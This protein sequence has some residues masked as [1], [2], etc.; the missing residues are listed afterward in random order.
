VADTLGSLLDE[1]TAA[2]AEAGRV[3][4]RRRARQLI[5]SSLNISAAELLMYPDRVL[6]RSEA[7]RLLGLVDRMTHG[8]PLS[9][10]LGRREFW[11]LDF[12]LSNE[13]LDPR[14]ESETVVEA[15][16]SRVCDRLSPLRLLDLGTGTGCL[17]LALLS[18][19]PAAT[20][21]GVDLSEEAVATARRNAET[22]G[23]GGRACFFVGEWSS[24]LA[25][26]FDVIVANPPYVATA[27]LRDLPDE[28][29]LYDP[30]RALEGGEDGLAAYR[31][32]ATALPAL[33][34]PFAMFVAEVGV[35]QAGAVAVILKGCGLSLEAIDRDL[36]GIE[37]CVVARQLTGRP[38]ELLAGGEKNLGMR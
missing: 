16:V 21:F 9:R 27:A 12:A 4:P 8:E 7:S 10:I 36:A 5:A 26:R 34:A 18:E 3:E 30:R 31:S 14:P 23:F 20:G 28:V 6:C 15:V 22:L 24:A 13:T 25:Q 33:L 1:A 17:L 29:S 37:R 19:F 32:I 38:A 2:L 35:G 11:S